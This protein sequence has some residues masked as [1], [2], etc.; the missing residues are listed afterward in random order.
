MSPENKRTIED[1][2][3]DF[4]NACARAGNA[5]YT[6]KQLELEIEGLNKQISDLNAEAMKLAKEAQESEKKVE[7]NNEVPSES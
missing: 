2:K 7:S 4:S 1:V 6:I 5:Q 3:R